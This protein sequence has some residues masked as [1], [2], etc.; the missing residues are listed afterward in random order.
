MTYKKSNLLNLLSSDGCP[1][2][3][4]TIGELNTSVVCW[5]PLVLS[6]NRQ[7]KSDRTYI[8]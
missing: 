2:V 5:I 7:E 8:A 6:A 3:G 4:Q 1:S